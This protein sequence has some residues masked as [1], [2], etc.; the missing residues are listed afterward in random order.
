[1]TTATR[2]EVYAAI[3]S[4]R[5]YQ[6]MR[7]T[8]DGSTSSEAHPH[9]HESFLLYMEHYLH[10]AR[11]KA[12]MTWGPQAALDT[13]EVVRKVVALGVACMEAHGAPQ[14]AGFEREAL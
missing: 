8:R 2:S 11:E 14:R 13:M 12:S 1:M 7:M 5:D 3:D 9:E 4:E 6:N 10:L